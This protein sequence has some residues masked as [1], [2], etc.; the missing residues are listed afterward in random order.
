MSIISVA[1]GIQNLISSG[2]SRGSFSIYNNAVLTAPNK[3]LYQSNLVLAFDGF[4]RLGYSNNVMIPQQTLE[5]RDF[6]NDSIIDNPFRLSLV[7]VISQ[8]ITS[9]T[10][11][12]SDYEG[13]IVTTLEYLGKSNTLLAIFRSTPLFSGYINMHLEDWNYDQT[14][15]KTAL[16]ANMSFREIRTNYIPNDDINQTTNDGL[17]TSD[18][19]SSTDSSNPANSST[20]DN[21][22]I[23][24]IPPSGDTNTLQPSTGKVLN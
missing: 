5:N 17:N 10:D 14:P 12:Y 1:S 19:F 22:I 20:V 4:V 8:Y 11:Y 7:A 9:I 24:T 2:Y 21:G 3:S 6:S 23:D 15:D 16:F 18:S 13:D